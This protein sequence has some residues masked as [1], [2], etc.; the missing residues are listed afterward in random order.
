MA[1][2]TYFHS[3]WTN[4]TLNPSFSHWVQKVKDDKT[5]ATCA[6]CKKTFSLIS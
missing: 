5:K 1:K 2:L 3:D 6:A 4:E